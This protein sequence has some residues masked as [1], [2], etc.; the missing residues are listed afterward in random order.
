MCLA[1]PA[2]VTLIFTWI[3]RDAW[4]TILFLLATY[5]FGPMA[6]NKMAGDFDYKVKLAPE[7]LAFSPPKDKAIEGKFRFKFTIFILDRI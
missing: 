5:Y 6:Y 2:L 7:M 4:L 3:F 1:A